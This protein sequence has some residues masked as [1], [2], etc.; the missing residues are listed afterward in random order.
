MFKWSPEREEACSILH[1][2]LPKAIEFLKI[3]SAVT[4]L[5]RLCGFLEDILEEDDDKMLENYELQHVQM[6]MD[7]LSPTLWYLKTYSLYWITNNES[8]QV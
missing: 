4:F 6:A 5:P 2:D 1:L 3:V 8:K 7:F